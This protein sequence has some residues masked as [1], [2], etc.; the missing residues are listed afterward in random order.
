MENDK[1]R[2]SREA[3]YQDSKVTGNIRHKIEKYYHDASTRFLDEY[4]NEIIGDLKDK[5]V[6][7]IGCGKGYYTLSCLTNGA[8]VTAIDIS[9]KSIELLNQMAAQGGGRVGLMQK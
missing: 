5:H 4:R 8:H 9:P 2:L 6:L 1:L 3:A 7:D